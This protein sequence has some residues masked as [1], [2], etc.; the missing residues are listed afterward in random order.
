MA[1]QHISLRMDEDTV[2]RLDTSSRQNGQTRSHLAKQLIEEGLRMAA[3]P[4]IVFQP[5]L[6]WREP[7]LAGGP[8]IWHIISV[9]RSLDLKGEEAIAETAEL[10]GWTIDQVRTAV[11]YY[12]D[13]PDEIDDFIDRND[14]E[15]ELAEAQWRRAQ[16]LPVLEAA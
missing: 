12:L 13:Y 11:R 2:K 8:K 5:S 4:G 3:H 1:T 16:G 9:Y 10:T 6:T 15:A 7:K 14:A